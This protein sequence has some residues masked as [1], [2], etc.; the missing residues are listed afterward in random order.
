MAKESDGGPNDARNSAE[1]VYWVQRKRD[2][3]DDRNRGEQHDVKGEF[4]Y[5]GDGREQGVH[6]GPDDTQRVHRS[7][8]QAK[9]EMKQHS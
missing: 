4:E 2:H 7:E 8:N 6:D 1:Y 9:P 5:D 3:G